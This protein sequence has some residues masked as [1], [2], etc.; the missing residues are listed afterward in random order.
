MAATQ[1]S[2]LEVAAWLFCQHPEVCKLQ[3]LAKRIAWLA[4]YAVAAVKPSGARYWTVGMLLETG[5]RCDARV[6]L[7][8]EPPQ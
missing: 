5:S 4:A 6:L 1:P 8:I 7:G 3:T 2:A